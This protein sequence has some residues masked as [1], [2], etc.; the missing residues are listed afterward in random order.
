M[1]LRRRASVDVRCGNEPRGELKNE[2]HTD[3]AIE[4]EIGATS[5]ADQWS[6]TS[7]TSAPNPVLHWIQTDGFSVLILGL[8]ELS[9]GE[10]HQWRQ[11][12]YFAGALRS[13]SVV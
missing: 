5:P 13:V 8:L 3:A 6:T 11:S 4:K 1:G 2:R 12:E 10:N 7:T 9:I